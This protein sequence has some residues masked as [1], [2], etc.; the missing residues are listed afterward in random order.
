MNA[1]L[2]VPP[3]VR[4]VV[5]EGHL[6][7]ARRSLYRMVR[8]GRVGWLRK[9]S[10]EGRVS[11]DWWADVPEMLN[12]FAARGCFPPLQVAR[13]DPVAHLQQQQK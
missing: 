1:P 8:E 5:I 3:V 4:L 7:F 11:R 13:P 12:F 10:P 2:K 9:V 6:P